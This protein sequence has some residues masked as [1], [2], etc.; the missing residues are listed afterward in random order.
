MHEDGSSYFTTK[1]MEAEYDS[2]DFYTEDVVDTEITEDM[3]HEDGSS[4]FTTKNMRTE[5]MYSDYLKLMDVRDSA[6]TLT[7]YFHKS[8][9]RFG[10]MLEHAYAQVCADSVLNYFYNAC[11]NN[12][13][14]ELHYYTQL[15]TQV[16]DYVKDA[17][18]TG[19]SIGVIDYSLGVI[20]AYFDDAWEQLVADTDDYTKDTEVPDYSTKPLNATQ[21]K[22][23]LIETMAASCT[24][25]NSELIDQLSD[26]SDYYADI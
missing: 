20:E 8:T 11:S 26:M 25:L 22:A 23:E 13:T 17:F 14:P 21:Y 24:E 12:N 15:A 16:S 9:D 5:A 3:M 7:D 4:Y 19:L 2:S 1:N 6:I 10:T 18:S